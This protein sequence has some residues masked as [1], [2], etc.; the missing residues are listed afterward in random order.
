M[1]GLA[2][3]VEPWHRFVNSRSMDLMRRLSHS[4]SIRT[5][6]VLETDS[7]GIQICKRNYLWE[8][9]YRAMGVEGPRLTITVYHK[10]IFNEH[11]C[12][13]LNIELSSRQIFSVFLAW[14]LN[15]EW[16]LSISSFVISDSWLPFPLWK[17]SHKFR[18]CEPSNVTSMWSSPITFLSSANWNLST[19]LSP[20]LDVSSLSFAKLLFCNE[21]W[22]GCE[23]FSDS[24]CFLALKYLWTIYY[25]PYVSSLEGFPIKA[26]LMLCV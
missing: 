18:I 17:L 4:L 12:V 22:S 21:G 26:S 10:H 8:M 19:I 15:A 14:V 1:R 11:T 23:W 7:I 2:V 6:P 20:L 16:K 24:F 25:W 3:S 5:F 13:R 9:N